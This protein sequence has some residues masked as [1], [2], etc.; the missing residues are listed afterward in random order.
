MKRR[1]LMVDDEADVVWS[2]GQQLGRE[3]ADLAFEGLNDP[4]Q[5]LARIRETPPDLLVTDVRMP[6]MNGLE[7]I[8][9]ARSIAPGL[10]VV[11]VTAYGSAEL[12]RE[13]Q[14]M[15]SVEYL[16]KPFGFRA[17]LAAIDRAMGSAEGFSG[18]ISV[19]FPDIIQLYALS[20][21]TGALRVS[22]GRETAVLWFEA[23]ALVHATLGDLRG[24]DAV[25]ALL[26]WKG[27]AFKLEA[28]SRA[29]DRSITSSWQELL[30]EGSRR[31]DEAAAAGTARDAFDLDEPEDA[32]LE[33]WRSAL[34]QGAGDSAGDAVF[35]YR[36]SEG[37]VVRVQGASDGPIPASDV[38][39][40]AGPLSR[41]AQAAK[42]GSVEAVTAD[43]G[44]GLLRGAGG[45]APDYVVVAPLGD[46]NAASRF[47]LRFAALS[48]SLGESTEE[49]AR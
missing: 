30:I 31:L 19:S 23:G 4:L 20:M 27:G 38:F 33:R 24:D 17:L 28:G 6:Q 34:A 26:L 42:A 36:A 12:R 5:A 41:L 3:R 21:A 45:N 47:R 16:D 11:V 10:P 7:L 1:V 49:A 48:K 29:S 22:R 14:G 13:V 44:I 15:T 35:A 2:M 9:A 43:L 8:L 39:D 37:R 25:Y 46:A 18:S 32:L 40:V